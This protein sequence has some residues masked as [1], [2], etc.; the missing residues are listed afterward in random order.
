ML[1]LLLILPPLLFLA[2]AGMFWW[3]MTRENPGELP[4]TFIGQAAPPLGDGVL[5][6]IAGVKAADL[7]AGKVT[8]V[9]FW[10]SWWKSSR[11]ECPPSRLP[12]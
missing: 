9:N 7:A 8:I 5:P 4:S 3:G 2:L 12:G 1:R 6:G 11:F 10:A